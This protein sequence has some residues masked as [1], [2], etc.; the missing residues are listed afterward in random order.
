[1]KFDNEQFTE[2]AFIFE[3]ENN[4]NHSEFEKNVIQNSELK[5]IVLVELE[6][7]IV[8]GIENGIYVDKFERVNAYWTLSKRYNFK[9]IPKFKRWLKNELE[10]EMENSIPIYQILIALDYLNEPVFAENRFSRDSAEIELN[11]RDAKNYLKK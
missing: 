7:I 10:S 6:E 1:M 2:I 3:K 8:R 5:D 11:I 9:L 4:Y